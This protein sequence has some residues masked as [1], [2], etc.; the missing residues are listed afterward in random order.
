MTFKKQFKPHYKIPRLFQIMDDEQ[1]KEIEKNL[2]EHPSTQ[3]HKDFMKKGKS[4]LR[5]M[6]S[7][8]YLAPF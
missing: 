4:P 6:K 7:F 2:I 5:K 8:F 3:S 1:M